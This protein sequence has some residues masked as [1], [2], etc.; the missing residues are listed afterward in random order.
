MKVS[1]IAETVA[2]ALNDM[3]TTGQREALEETAMLQTL[4][5]LMEK[6]APGHE[7]LIMRAVDG[8]LVGFSCRVSTQK[9]LPVQDGSNA[10]TGPK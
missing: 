1:K 7:L 8:C 10:L 9:D 5:H 4:N 2:T 6:L 3:L